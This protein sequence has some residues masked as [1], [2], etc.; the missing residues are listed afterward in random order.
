MKSVIWEIHQRKVLVKCTPVHIRVGQEITQLVA[1]SIIM[2]HPEALVAEE[3]RVTRC[4]LVIGSKPSGKGQ[5][6]K[7]K[8]TV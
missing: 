4:K 5:K 2:Q 6:E 3:T 8:F 1:L 7:L